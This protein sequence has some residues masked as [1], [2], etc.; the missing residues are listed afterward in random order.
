MFS[1]FLFS[2]LFDDGAEAFSNALSFVKFSWS[3]TVEDIIVNIDFEERFAQ[4]F[5]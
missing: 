3:K 4:D 1:E 2:E 5:F